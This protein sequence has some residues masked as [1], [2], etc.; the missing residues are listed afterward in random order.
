[1]ALLV[2]L[3]LLGTLSSIL[4]NEQELR[5]DL[6]NTTRH[7]PLA[8]PRDSSEPINVT[9]S[10]VTG[11]VVGLDEIDGKFTIMGNLEMSWRDELMRWNKEKY[12]VSSIVVIGK[13]AWTPPIYVLNKMDSGFLSNGLKDD[14]LRIQHTGEVSCTHAGEMAVSCPLDPKD[15]PFDVQSCVMMFG[16]TVHSSLEVR[17]KF[18][19]TPIQSVTGAGIMTVD[20]PIWTITGFRTTAPEYLNIASI[21]FC[22]FR[23]SLYYTFT[24]FG[25]SALLN[26]LTIFAFLI[27]NDQG[28]K[29]SCGMTIFL[30]F[31]VFLVQVGDIIPKNSNAVPVLGKYYLYSIIGSAIMVINTVIHSFIANKRLTNGEI[32][33]EPMN[34]DLEKPSTFDM[35]DDT[36]SVSSNGITGKKNALVKFLKKYGLKILDVICFLTSVLLIGISVCMLLT[37]KSK[38]DSV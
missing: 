9:L 7:N 21:K 37:T 36:I 1:M 27:P 22:L 19:D 12:N 11:F 13:E 18:S 28:E 23:K 33:V 10:W 2:L 16:L 3:G 32:K 24:M 38:C 26:C 17:L 8:L 31:V 35:Y 30:A 29:I 20:H 4:C 5:S 6:F 15:F 34:N 14:L 25:P